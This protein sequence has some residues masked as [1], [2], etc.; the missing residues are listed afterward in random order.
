MKKVTE[1][2]RV[3]IA[4]LRNLPVIKDLVADMDPFFDKW[5]AAEGLHHPDAR[6]VRAD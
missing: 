4:P 5:I 1:N 3:D 2:D 6:S